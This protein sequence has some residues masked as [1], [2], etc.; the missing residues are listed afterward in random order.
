VINKF[1]IK[2]EIE[3]IIMSKVCPKCGA[4]NKINDLYCTRCGANLSEKEPNEVILTGTMRKSRNLA[5]MGCFLFGIILTI[6]TSIMSITTGDPSKLI[7]GIIVIWIIILLAM[8]PYLI[9]YRHPNE[10]WRFSISDKSIKFN[11][12]HKPSF[13][14]EWNEFKS[15]K[16][17]RKRTVI[18]I[19][20]RYTKTYNDV[21]FF[22][23]EG[24]PRIFS[25]RMGKDYPRSTCKKIRSLLK[26]YANRL[27]KKYEYEKSFWD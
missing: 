16:V 13:R 21:Q 23:D 8:V 25:I 3:V 14:I 4:S 26:E 22:T 17:K 24:Y 27:N 18:G 2:N 1:Y 10:P 9:F 19:K 7:L 5:L 20:V 15:I 12:S 6:G 11:T